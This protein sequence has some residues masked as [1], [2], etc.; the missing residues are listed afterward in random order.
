MLI[1]LCLIPIM[2]QAQNLETSIIPEKTT[3]I[4]IICFFLGIMVRAISW[5]LQ[6]EEEPGGCFVWIMGFLIGLFVSAFGTIGSVKQSE[7][8]LL[9]L[10]LFVFGLILPTLI[11]FTIFCIKYKEEK[12]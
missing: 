5:L 7:L 3:I 10:F 4:S 11:D 12:T 2:M 6:I 9:N 8:M 1:I